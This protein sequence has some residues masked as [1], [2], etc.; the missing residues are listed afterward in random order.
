MKGV[1]GRL[2]VLVAAGFTVGAFASGNARASDIACHIPVGGASVRC[3]DPNG[4]ERRCA[5]ETD[6]SRPGPGGQHLICGSATLSQRYER[7]Y[8]EQQRL[9]RKRSIQE[10]DITAWRATRDACSSERCLDSLFHLFWRQRDAMRNAPVQ[11]A[12][13]A[14]AA[15]TGP[16]AASL[17]P[18]PTPAAAPPK[19]V[20]AMPAPAGSRAAPPAELPPGE[21]AT[22]NTAPLSEP[23]SPGQVSRAALALESLLGGLA[24][25]GAG[26]LSS[27]R[28]AHALDEMRPAL[29][30]ALVIVYGLLLVNA[31][32]LPF[33]L[34]LK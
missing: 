18:M 22:A 28:R 12:T 1:I 10:A 24:V 7:I 31:L 33:T 29:P 30:A 27:R 21:A 19:P 8:A 3:E 4:N 32:L 13:R 9:L 6:I 2:A 16:A 25:L 34:G 17:D 15:V 20:Q 23:A 26:F 11:P 5:L 14:P